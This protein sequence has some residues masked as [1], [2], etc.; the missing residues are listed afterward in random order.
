MV[1]DMEVNNLVDLQNLEARIRQKIQQ[2]ELDDFLGTLLLSRPRFNPFVIA[3][4]TLFGIRFALPPIKRYASVKHIPPEEFNLIAHL[5]TEYLLADPSS[6]L[7]SI[8]S[9]YHGSVLTPVV[10]RHVGNQ[11]PFN[12]TFWG[13][14]GRSIYLFK[15]IPK[16]LKLKGNKFDLNAAFSKLYGVSLEDFIS[17]SYVAFSAANANRN[18]GQVGFSGGYFQKARDQGMALP[19]GVTVDAIMDKIAAD[20][21]QMREM[22]EQFKQEDRN[23]GAYDF[24]PLFVYPIV[25]PWRKS[26]LTSADEDRFVAPLPELILTRLSSGVH[27]DLAFNFKSGFP[28]YFGHVFEKYVGEVLRNC[29]SSSSIIAEEEIRRTYSDK[30]G[31]SPDWVIIEGDMA[32]L[33]ECKAVGY[34]RKA[35]ST[36]DA[37]TIDQTIDKI[38][39]GLVQMHEFTAAC[40]RKE[41]GLERFHACTEY[42]PLLLTY[43]PV[44]LSNSNN[45]R[46]VLEVKVNDELRPKGLRACSWVIWSIDELEK[47]QPH[48]N[49]GISMQS[50]MD[51]YTP[52]NFNECLNQLHAQTGCTFKDS[53]LALKEREVYQSMGIP[54]DSL[55]AVVHARELRK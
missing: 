48:L 38:A 39:D 27:E 26:S 14:G 36:G 33:V 37:T 46:G 13:Q 55:A 35:L 32:T 52:S 53:F 8:K 42:K 20:Q 29:V 54:S 12:E 7:P 2:H 51:L 15:E 3:G 50:A 6:F 22:Y 40:L 45:L 9:T 16:T 31:K 49:A 4:M 25:R 19:D 44:Y 30:R 21:W 28:K 47:L 5:V 11:F 1:S 34:Q 10:L 43:E 23:Y 17:V 24:N 41:P 18:K